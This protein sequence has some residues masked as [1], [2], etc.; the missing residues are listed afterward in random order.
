MVCGAG[1]TLNFKVYIF[2]NILIISYLS[3]LHNKFY[4]V[5]FFDMEVKNDI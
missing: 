4:F 2:N 3:E 5:S 1:A